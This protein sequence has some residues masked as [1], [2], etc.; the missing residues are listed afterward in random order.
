MSVLMPL[1]LRG[2]MGS[3]W[4]LVVPRAQ[5]HSRPPWEQLGSLDV[6]ITLTSCFVCFFLPAGWV[7]SHLESNKKQ[8]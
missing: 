4:R 7:L 2:L 1:L 5:V 6:A 3:A 8:E